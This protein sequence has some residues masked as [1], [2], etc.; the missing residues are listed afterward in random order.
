MVGTIMKNQLYELL[1]NTIK[2]AKL[3]DIECFVIEK[4]LI[5]GIDD[6]KSIFMNSHHDCEMPAD[7]GI[8]RVSLLNNR[9][10][11]IDVEKSKFSETLANN[12]MCISSIKIQDGRSRLEIRCANV[13]LIQSQK[14]LKD[15]PKYK[16]SVKAE[17][18]AQFIKSNQAMKTEVVYLVNEDGRVY[19]DFIDTNKDVLQLDIDPDI[20]AV[21]DAVIT[22]FKY[23]YDPAYLQ[24]VLKNNNGEE[25]LMGGRG[26]LRTVINNINV[27]LLPK[28]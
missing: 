27:W 28:V 4:N 5:R 10:K 23:A 13:A 15:L 8:T 26:T 12:K 3:L 9:I 25:L 2:T 17:D 6:T 14:N 22:N 7:I 24:L 20:D 1:L 18:V 11:L 19:F 21:E 16:L